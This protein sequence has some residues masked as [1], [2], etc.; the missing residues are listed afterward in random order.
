ML[1]DFARPGCAIG[2]VLGVPCRPWAAHVVLFGTIGIESCDHELAQEVDD[3]TEQPGLLGPGRGGPDGG[4]EKRHDAH[5]LLGGDEQQFCAELIK[6][7]L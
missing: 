1:L 7:R 4:I 6:K 5:L 2:I 3:F